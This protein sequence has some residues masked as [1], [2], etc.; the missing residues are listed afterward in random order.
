MGVEVVACGKINI[1]IMMDVDELPKGAQHIMANSSSISVGGSAANFA[2]HSARL[3]VKTK[4]VACVGD[5]FYGQD[6]TKRISEKGVDTS[7]VQTIAGQPT[8]LF[9]LVRKDEQSSFIIAEAGANSQL[10]EVTLR[11][12]KVATA[13]TIH[14]AGGFPKI[15]SE[16]A[17]ITTSEGIVLSLD[18]GRKAKNI[19]FS[20]ILPY[21]DL[22]FLN[23]EELRSYFNMEPTEKHLKVLGK[24]VPGII[25]VKRGGKGTMATNGFEFYES[26]A[27]EVAVAD[28]LGAGDAFAAGF[29]TA[30]TR[31]EDIELALHM[32]N[33]VA[34]LTIE[35]TG[36]QNGPTLKQTH[37]LLSQ[38]GIN[39][40]PI[41]RTLR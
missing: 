23:E 9:F 32:G 39:T 11:R 3:G 30:W 19:D 20:T 16:V 21:I 14:I 29:I 1:D 8:G 24:K 33:A 41:L 12:K 2:V 7:M 18:P 28:T 37:E 10:E 36:A 31:S 34:A 38:Y 15:I 17:R 5:D 4:L 25:V 35:E 6:A 40:D 13:R 27:F 26:K 22:L